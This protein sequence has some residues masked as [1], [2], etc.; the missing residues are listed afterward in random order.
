[1]LKIGYDRRRTQS[2]TR[3]DKETDNRT[4]PEWQKK[5]AGREPFGPENREE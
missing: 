2:V 5:R 3:P 4:S 1:M